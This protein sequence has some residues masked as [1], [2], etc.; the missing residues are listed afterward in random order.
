MSREEAS[1]Q[2]VALDASI[3]FIIVVAIFRLRRYEQISVADLKKGKCKI[4]D[5]AVYV[6]NIPISEKDY[7]KSP[8]LL[9]AMIA[10]HFEDICNNEV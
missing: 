1:Y 5:F 7:N 10:T 9:K 2:I 6:P 8:E 4:E 3:I